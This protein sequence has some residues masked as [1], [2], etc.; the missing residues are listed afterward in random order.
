MTGDGSLK[1][2]QS[3]RRLLLAI[4]NPLQQPLLEQFIGRN[5]SVLAVDLS[6]DSGFTF[7][8]AAAGRG[9][10]AGER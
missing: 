10:A 3:A 4:L 6:G 5:S 1:G 2:P 7:G 8:P 9:A